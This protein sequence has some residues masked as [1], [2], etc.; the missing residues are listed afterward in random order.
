[1]QFGS[2]L[3]GGAA[4]DRTSHHTQDGNDAKDTVE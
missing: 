4:Q 3:H 1:L 2:L